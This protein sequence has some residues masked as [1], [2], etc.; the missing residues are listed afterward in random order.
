MSVKMKDDVDVKSS[1]ETWRD[2][3]P[4]Y[5]LVTDGKMYIQD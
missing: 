2:M 4:L 5:L 1:I 3:G